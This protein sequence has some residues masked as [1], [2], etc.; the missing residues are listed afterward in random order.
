MSRDEILK[1]LHAQMKGLRDT[2]SASALAYF[3][4]YNKE[5]KERYE[6]SVRITL[7]RFK[8]LNETYNWLYLVLPSYKV[9]K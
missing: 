5:D 6:Q 7:A 8:Q 3:E 2:A 4:S 9:E 1:E